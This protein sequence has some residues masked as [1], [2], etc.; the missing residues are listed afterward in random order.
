MNESAI[1]ID[2]EPN[3]MP[4][5]P[6][7]TDILPS[8]ITNTLRMRV[9]RLMPESLGEINMFVTH[10]SGDNVLRT[11]DMSLAHTLTGQLMTVQHQITTRSVTGRLA[12]KPCKDLSPPLSPLK[13]QGLSI[14]S[15]I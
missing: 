3:D 1:S 6:E 10:P 15:I 11:E 5:L 12:K 4:N 9:N 7:A 2:F 13:K 8:T 14:S